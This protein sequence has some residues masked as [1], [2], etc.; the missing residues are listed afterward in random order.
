MVLGALNFAT[1][2][3]LLAAPPTSSPASIMLLSNADGPSAKIAAR[4]CGRCTWNVK[5]CCALA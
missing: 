2:G 4:H 5:L 1:L 3:V